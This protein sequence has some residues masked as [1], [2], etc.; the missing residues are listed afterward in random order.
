MNGDEYREQRGAN[1]LNHSE[2]ALSSTV[3]A[4]GSNE[5]SEYTVNV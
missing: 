3:E 4:E 1:A 2:G 5:V